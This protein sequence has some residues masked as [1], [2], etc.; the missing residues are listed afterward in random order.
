M[1]PQDQR[2][3]TMS[4]LSSIGVKFISAII[5]FSALLALISTGLQLY[6]D[7]RKDYHA[8]SR[9]LSYLE[10]S[11]Q[12]SLINEI[13][14][15]N[16]RGVEEQMKGM[17][18]LPMIEAVRLER[19][20]GQ[21]IEV[22]Q[23][24]ARRTIINRFPLSHEFRGKV[25]PLGT[26]QIT[27]SAD[28]A[29]ERMQE[30][31]LLILLA[32]FV[33]FS[34]VAAFIFL[35]FYLMVGRHLSA[36]ARHAR[37]M[38][39]GSLDQPLQL[40]RPAHSNQRQ[41]ELD[42]LV[43]A[44]NQMQQQLG[45]YIRK[46]L[47]TEE[48]LRQEIEERKIIEDTL[49]EQAALLEEEVAERQKTQEELNLL[50]V[51]LEE[52]IESAI[53]ELRQ[54]DNLLMHQSRLAAMGELLNSIAHQWRQP[55]NNIAAYIQNIQYLNRIGE[56][57]QEEMD[58][59]IKEV[60]EILLYM[61]HTID[62]FRAFFSKDRSKREFVVQEVVEKTLNLS[63]SALDDKNIKVSLQADPD[64][65]ATGYPNEYAQALLNILYNARDVL[66]ERSVIEPRIEI[67]ISR[68]EERSLVTV[69]DNGGGIGAAVM[70]HIF[71]PYF[72]TKGP[73]QGTG[74]GLYM[75]RTIIEH[76]MGGR[77]SAVNTANGAEF[78]IEL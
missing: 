40:H 16:D 44:F 17:L 75:A 43:G 9:Q 11:H 76:N 23:V 35:L 70:P 30:R 61:S 14:A 73:S 26:L 60:M 54:K 28:Y 65:R 51:R 47:Q 56:L 36:M 48:Q 59:D 25:L 45:G 31:A 22:G 15:L 67:T 10:T 55:L 33:E 39:A 64:V 68:T 4:R 5:L 74:I 32:K 41:D 29:F 1:Q 46:R 71:E 49:H 52:R 42:Q 34:A 69:Q 58:R 27:A 62:D 50:N 77:L 19:P 20:D 3:N 63:K 57:T 24:K 72:S 21:A 38:H 12:K 6:I 18:G 7:Y 2:D 37:E 78:R 53:A 66:L 13:W 8:V